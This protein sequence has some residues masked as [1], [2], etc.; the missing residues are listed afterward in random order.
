VK[1]QKLLTNNR[2]LLRL[3]V[4]FLI[5]SVLLTGILMIVV[6][7]F[8]SSNIKTQ[9]TN[10]AT[11]L[12][13]QSY[14]TAYYSLTNI[15]GD[16]YDLWTKNVMVLE[17]LNTMAISPNNNL[18]SDL[19]DSEIIR[20]DLLDSIYI[21][22]KASGS[23]ISNVASYT[24]DSF[25]DKDAL[26][27][28]DE[29]ELNYDSYKNELF[30]PRST[31]VEIQD[32]RIDKNLISIVYARKN[33]EGKIN[34][35][36][37]VNID[38]RKLSTLI[39]I[40]NDSSS[41]LIVNS[42]G[43]IISD[44][45]GNFGFTIPQDEFYTSIANNPEIEN[46]LSSNYLDEKSFV[47]YKKAPDLGLVFISITPY[48]ALNDQ[49]WK[50]EVY[51]AFFFIF[52]MILSLIFSFISIKKIYEPLDSL[53]Q[54]IKS[55]PAIQTPILGDEY[56][57]LG[58]TYKSLV[59]KD[60]SSHV[61]R[62]FNGSYSDNTLEVLN[63]YTEDKFMTFVVIPDK[64]EELNS[65]CIESIVNIINENTRWAGAITSNN[66]ISCII[67]QLGFS[68]DKINSIMEGLINLQ[69]VISEE[70]NIT[71]SIGLG[72]MVN[73]LDS[74]KFSHRYAMLATQ[75]AIDNGEN[76]I[77]LY[78]DIETNKIVASQNKDTVA[79]KIQ[80]YIDSNFTRQDFSVDE[81][82]TEIDLSL[83]YIRQ[84]FKNE[85]GMSLN[86]YIINCRVELS[87]TLLLTT[88]KTAKDIAEDV[89][90]YDN[91]YFYTLFKKKVGM[92][93][94]EFRNSNKDSQPS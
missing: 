85:K 56:E 77:V 69:N 10:A 21:I 7:S 52:A 12:L 33:E 2:L 83:S 94:D 64:S 15:Y 71:V 58:E 72:T 49:V 79:D 5:I 51:M 37:I 42:S 47:T 74:I 26:R 24:L 38:Q 28:F 61:A 91:R 84:I 36:I 76:H 62:I 75:H 46:S 19:L 66:C 8:V 6:S 55:N 48:S 60:K 17:F 92:T 90:Y 23:V 22:N 70:L 41:M 34:S 20:N 67:N 1:F 81:I 39:N 11:D 65:E 78:N 88:D 45:D 53:I 57:F 32:N 87:K 16:Y 82:A 59:L 86:D 68:E 43:N 35:G 4:S 63:Y 30:F 80:E 89:G 27:L 9:T 44:L 18:I 93:T 50:V 73:N 31:S 25:Y 40:D 3:I 29:F 54:K 14:S 13:K